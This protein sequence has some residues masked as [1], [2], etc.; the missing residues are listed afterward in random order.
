MYLPSYVRDSASGL[1]CGAWL[2]RH[3]WNLKYLQNQVRDRYWVYQ[4]RQAKI[5]DHHLGEMTEGWIGKKKGQHWKTFHKWADR[6]DGAI[7]EAN[8]H[9][10]GSIARTLKAFM[11]FMPASR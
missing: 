7:N 5:A 1:P 8:A 9:A 2:C 11:P 6:Y 4:Y 3:C 10:F